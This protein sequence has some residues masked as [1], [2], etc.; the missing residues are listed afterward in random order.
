M[1]IEEA[2]NNF[3]NIPGE[4]VAERGVDLI[5]SIYNDFRE[6]SCKNCYW[7]EGEICIHGQSPKVADFPD[8]EMMCGWWE[9]MQL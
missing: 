1:T 2:I 4:E 5:N 6:A 3:L 7:L 9:H 8:T